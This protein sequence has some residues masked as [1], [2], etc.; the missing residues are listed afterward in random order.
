[1]KV[2][3]TGATRNT[4][5]AIIRG[6]ASAGC[7][8]IGADERKLPFNMHSRYSKPYYSYPSEYHEDFLD[9]II[10]MIKKERPDVLLPVCGTKQISE[11]KMVIEEH[12]K[13]LV[14]DYKSFMTAY[15]NQLLLEECKKLNIDCPKIWQEKDV[16]CELKNNRNRTAPVRFVLKPRA[17]IGGS[18]GMGVFH[19]E[20][21]FKHLKKR[22]EK[23]GSAFISE[24]IP[25]DPENMRAVNM[26][27]DGNSE[28]TA[29][30]TKKKSANGHNPAVSALYPSVHMSRT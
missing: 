16:L 19:D 18:R 27:F 21:S 24:Y 25:G 20:A 28:L 8:V 23:Y 15:D 7:E 13:V 26:L 9:A 3:V 17:D 29:Y 5:M 10:T 14:P 22:A 1:M 12:T 6:L 4:S 2:I 11:H 30:F